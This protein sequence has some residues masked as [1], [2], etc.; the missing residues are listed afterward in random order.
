MFFI[1]AKI[2]PFLKDLREKMNS[3]ASWSNVETVATRSKSARKRLEMMTK[4]ITNRRKAMGK[5]E[6]KS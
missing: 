5:A 4:N 3:P 6:K 1:F 2:H